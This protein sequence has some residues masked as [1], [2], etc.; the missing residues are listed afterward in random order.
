[1]GDHS[2]LEAELVE[3]FHTAIDTMNSH[4]QL[5]IAKREQTRLKKKFAEGMT[6]LLTIP[7]IGEFSPH[8]KGPYVIEKL[9]GNGTAKIRD[10]L[11][12]PLSFH[13]NVSTQRL[14]I[15]D[16]PI[17]SS[18]NDAIEYEVEKITNHRSEDNGKRVE[19]L[20]KWCGFEAQTWELLANFRD[21]DGVVTSALTRY[22][23]DHPELNIDPFG[24]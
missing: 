18:S 11:N 17:P 20:T 5:A 3:G 14:K 6:V 13:P 2:T 8:L 7:A 10:T 24:E 12:K 21:R 1:M 19:F 16:A 22:L 9:L 23:E 4:N 15:L